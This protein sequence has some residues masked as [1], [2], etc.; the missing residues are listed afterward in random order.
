MKT[1]GVRTR[2]SCKVVEVGKPGPEYS[3]SSIIGALNGL[4]QIGY[5]V[6]EKQLDTDSKSEAT[7]TFSRRRHCE[8]SSVATDIFIQDDSDIYSQRGS[9]GHIK[10]FAFFALNVNTGVRGIFAPA[11]FHKD[12]SKRSDPFSSE[13]ITQYDTWL[14]N[15]RFTTREEEYEAFFRRFW[16]QGIEY[17]FFSRMMQVKRGNEQFT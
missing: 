5:N 3:A 2:R 14:V 13:L 8:L 10:Q 11:E 15:N 1:D 7:F 16:G 4:H 9:G 12:E 17:K 6:H